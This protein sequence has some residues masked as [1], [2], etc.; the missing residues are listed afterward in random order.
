VALI[1]NLRRAVQS[2]WIARSASLIKPQEWLIIAHLLPLVQW[3]ALKHHPDMAY[4]MEVA[5]KADRQRGFSARTDKLT[6]Y[7]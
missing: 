4:D 6:I 2:R 1:S 5:L 7:C 3:L